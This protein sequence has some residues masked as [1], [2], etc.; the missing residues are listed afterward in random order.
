VYV[1]RHK[2]PEKAEAEYY[3][4]GLHYFGG[5]NLQVDENF[6]IKG[7]TDKCMIFIYNRLTLLDLLVALL[8]A[9]LALLASSFFS[10]GQDTP[11]IAAVITGGLCD[12]IVRVGNAQGELGLSLFSHRRGGHVWFIPMWI[13][14]IIGYLGYAGSHASGH[15]SND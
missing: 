1:C 11:V 8:G 13:I 6:V 7:E 3:P 10:L 5:H 2:I 14:A 15:G 12:I 4:F 9:G